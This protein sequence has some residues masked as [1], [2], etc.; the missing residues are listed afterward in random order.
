MRNGARPEAYR[1]VQHNGAGA[2]IDD[3]FCCSHRGLDLQLFHFGNEVHAVVGV[4]GGL[5]LHGAPIKCLRHA[6]TEFAVDGHRHLAGGLKIGGVQAQV[7]A[8]AFLQRCGHRAL[9]LRTIGN[10]ACAQVVYRD[11]A[12]TRCRSGTGHDHVAL[13]QGVDLAIGSFEWGCNQGSALERFGISQR[14]HI[15]VKQL[16]WPCK[17][18]QLRSDQHRR[19]VFHLQL[20]KRCRGKREPQLLHVVAQALGGV[21]HL[22]GLVASAVQAH[23]QAEAGEL[24]AAYPFDCGYFLDAGGMRWAKPGH[25]HRHAQQREV[26]QAGAFCR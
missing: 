13:R 14:G 7:D 17:S 9:D 8:G 19:H 24:V 15:D 10:A 16:P 6:V 11:L 18:G 25:E 21:G 5:D 12:S 22:R 1:L 3:D 23:N 2:R 20:G 26:P 4:G